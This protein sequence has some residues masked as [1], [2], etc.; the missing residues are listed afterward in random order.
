MASPVTH[1]V[2]AC[3]LALWCRIPPTAIRYWVLGNVCAQLPDL[4]VVGFWLDIPYEHPFGHRGITHS[5][6]FALLLSWCAAF[7]A[8]EWGPLRYG[9]LWC[10]LFFAALSHGLLDAFT[11]GGLGVA[12]F[13]PFDNTRY[14]FPLHPIKVTPLE[15]ERALGPA[16][17]PVLLSE[18]KWVWVPCT[19]S[20]GVWWLARRRLGR[21]TV[22][23]SE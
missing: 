15:P 10:Y 19:L 23:S 7:W 12:F 5:I 11:D 20:L 16:A 18:A 3:T 22:S 6:L 14:F 8:R 21:N 17:I 9:P 2:V 1:A 4:D 13:A